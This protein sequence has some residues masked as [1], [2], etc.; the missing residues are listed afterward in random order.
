M[1]LPSAFPCAFLGPSPCHRGERAH[2]GLHLGR[3]RGEAA[4]GAHLDD[5]SGAIGPTRADCYSSERGLHLHWPLGDVLGSRAL[6]QEAEIL[7]TPGELRGK[8]LG[9]Q[10]SI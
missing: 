3:R 10:G 7:I 4:A 9:T 1:T 8:K 6:S 2:D 5:V